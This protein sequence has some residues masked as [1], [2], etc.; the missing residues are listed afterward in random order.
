MR[1]NRFLAT[2]GVGARRTCEDIIRDGRI[3]VN[4]RIVTE[5]GLVV[6]ADR[7]TVEL[8]GD[9][10]GTAV[11]LVYALLNKPAGYVVT[12][13]D[14]Q[15]RP[16]VFHLLEG[17]EQRI[18][19]VGRLDLDVEGLLLL[20]NDGDLGFRLTHPRYEVEKTYQA[21]ISGKPD[22][23]TLHAIEEGMQLEDGPTAPIHVTVFRATKNETFLEMKMHEGR[24]RQIKRMWSTLGHPVISLVRTGFASI[25]LD[26]V[27]TGQWRYLTP[28]E[29][30]RLRTKVGLSR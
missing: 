4:G 18:F 15:N 24:K 27:R 30:Q 3:S 1:L 21:V 11:K 8:D 20:T 7:D 12:A 26:G 5:L 17:I 10:I 2:Q 28:E 22:K 23:Q 14:P 19:P 6:E 29:V 25:T 16:T 13:K 9:R